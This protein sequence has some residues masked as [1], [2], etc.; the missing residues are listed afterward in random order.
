MSYIWIGIAGVLGIV[1]FVEVLRLFFQMLLTADAW[2]ES[3]VIIPISGH[4]EDIEY[5]VR[6]VLFE[7]GWKNN[8]KSCHILVVDGGIDEETRAICELLGREYENVRICRPQEVE[9]IVGHR[10]C[11]VH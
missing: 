8:L 4:K 7:E 2:R 11:V 6:G 9:G 1:G 10:F 5:L 3:Y